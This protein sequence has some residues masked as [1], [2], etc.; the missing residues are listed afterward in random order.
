M[1]KKR[2]RVRRFAF[3]FVRYDKSLTQQIP[4]RDIL[5]V[6]A[7][8]YAFYQVRAVAICTSV[9]LCRGYWEKKRGCTE[10]VFAIWFNT[11]LRTQEQIR[12]C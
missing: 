12:S 8:V 4:K 10:R 11:F 3:R 2:E 9:Y 5:S 6:C 1:A 7:L